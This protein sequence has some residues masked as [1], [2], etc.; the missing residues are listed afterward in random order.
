M[1]KSNGTSKAPAKINVEKVI[2][3][4]KNKYPNLFQ[5]AGSRYVREIIKSF[6]IPD[7]KEKKNSFKKSQGIRA[8][9]KPGE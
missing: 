9:Q 7:K 6:M 3:K 1:E 4:I 2:I 5:D 8:F